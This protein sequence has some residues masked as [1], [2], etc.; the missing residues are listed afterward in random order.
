MFDITIKSNVT[1]TEEENMEMLSTLEDTLRQK[2]DH[3][4]NRIGKKNYTF[5]VKEEIKKIE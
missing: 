3:Y 4:Y 5:S 2:I 1:D